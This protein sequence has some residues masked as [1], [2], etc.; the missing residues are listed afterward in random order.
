MTID[1]RPRSTELANQ[2][3]ELT[4][5]GVHS[6]VRLAGPSV[7]FE[8][9]QGAWLYDADGND[10]VDYLLGQGPNFL[11]HAP[12][13]VNEAVARESARGAVFGAQH[14]LE[15]RAGELF[16]DSVRWAER[17]R[18]GLTGTEADQAALRLARAA[19][20]KNRFI[21]FVGTY[22]GWL[23][24]VLVKVADGAAQP[25][26]R[27][28]LGHHLDD[29]YFVPFNDLD[30]VEQILTTHDDVAALIIE[31]VM[32]N[33]AAITPNDGYLAALRR[34]CDR[35]GVVLI[36]DE[37]ITGFRLALGGAAERFDVTPDL[38]VYGKAMAGG[39]PVAAVAGRADIM[40]ALIDGVNHSGTF[41]SSIA[42]C[43]AVIATLT[44]LRENPPYESVEAHGAKLMDVVTQA[45][46]AHGLPLR[47]QGLPAAFHVSFGPPDRIGDHATVEAKLDLA[48]YAE[49]AA[50]L[51][52]HG[53]WV[54]P[55][56]IWYVS[57][58]HG[59]R[60]L[61][62]TVDRLDSALAAVVGS[63]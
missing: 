40:D 58:A 39:W 60:E 20:G 49:L 31:P 4:P 42:A 44:E 54:A 59:E 38:A 5:G 61:T 63:R 34:L 27:G 22:H 7:F 26:S 51:V 16:L 36:F 43:A 53:I 8:R 6:N 19:T 62:A 3:N 9:G 25:A 13:R 24:N 21:R 52:D 11:G 15:N 37:V 41:N 48:R 14:V 30:A 45:G 57:A 32:C 35:H 12:R 17:V 33:S 23:D 55:R 47:V 56:G 28:Q 2:A 1:V 46:A 29:T 18:F 10:Y 50:V